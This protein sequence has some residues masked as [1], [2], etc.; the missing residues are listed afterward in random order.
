MQ[1]KAKLL[2]VTGVLALAGAGGGTALISNA[3]AA[4]PAPARFAPAQ[5]PA[6]APASSASQPAA[7]PAQTPSPDPANPAAENAPENSA[8]NAPESEAGQPGEPAVGHAD[9]AGTANHECTGNC[10]E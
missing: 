9:L 4:S 3:G 2:A 7:V 1:L 8:E 10:V 5:T 6:V